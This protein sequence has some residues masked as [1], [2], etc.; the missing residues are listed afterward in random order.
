MDSREMYNATNHLTSLITW[1]NDW[2][3]FGT[4]DEIKFDLIKQIIKDHLNDNDL[5]FIHHRTNS[6]Q[7]NQKVIIDTIKPILGREDFQLWSVLMDKVI[8][9]KKIGVLNLGQ[10]K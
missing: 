7:H 4:E 1:D 3:H 5:L 2:I 9:F 8:Q 10:K 6:G